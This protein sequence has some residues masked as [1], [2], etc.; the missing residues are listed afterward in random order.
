M[1]NQGMKS[2]QDISCKQAPFE[3]EGQINPLKTG[4]I[5]SKHTKEE[6]GKILLDLLIFYTTAFFV[7]LSI[8]SVAAMIFLVPFFIDPAW[9]TI[10]A[11]FKENGSLCQ[12]IK[13]HKMEGDNFETCYSK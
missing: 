11:N 7:L 1:V 4:R 2:A 10:R 13:A 12:T 8:I 5:F 9:S 3:M 6:W